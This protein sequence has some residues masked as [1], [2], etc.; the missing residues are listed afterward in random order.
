MAR[1]GKKKAT[2][3]KKNRI[4]SYILIFFSIIFILFVYVESQIEPIL[5]NIAKARVKQIATNAVNDAI[6]TKI[7]NNTK[8]EDLIQF[9]FDNNGNVRAAI[10]NY[11]EFAKIVGD[12]TLQIQETLNDLK[13]LEESVKFGAVLNSDILANLGPSIPIKILPVGSVQ[14]SPRAEYQNAGINVVIMTVLIDVRTE[15]QV[16][17]PFVS[18][19]SILQYSI[20][21][22]QS[23][24]FG[25]VPQFYYDAKGTYYG[26]TGDSSTLPIQIFPESIIPNSEE[27]E[28]E[29]DPVTSNLN[30]A[31]PVLG[32]EEFY[33]IISD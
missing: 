16:V 2:I 28:I 7:A 5:I 12:A 17:I 14:V 30:E 3:N 1:W 18:E 22:V 9:D 27:I 23:Q 20:P 31:M 19:L 10:L 24:I 29:S 32:F 13:S 6:S 33:P 4:L 8:F 25:D 26:N 11:N 21:I 15:I